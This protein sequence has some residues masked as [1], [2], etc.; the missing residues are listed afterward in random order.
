M[1]WEAWFTLSVVGFILLALARNWAQ[2]DIILAGALTVLMTAGLVSGSDRLPGPKAAV[3]GFGNAGPLT[4]GVLF[5]V[6]QGL[7]RTGAMGRLTRPFLG[8]PRGAFGA[9]CRLILPV[10]TLSAFLNNTP[11]VAMFMPVLSDWARKARISPSRLFIPLSYASIFGG[12]CTLIGT[13]TNLVIAGLVVADGDLPAIGMFDIA[14]IGLPCAVAGIVYMLL[15]GRWL[16]PDRKP[17]VSMNDDPRQYTVE[18]IVEPGGVLVGKTIEQAGLRHLPGLYLVEIERR[19][20]KLLPAVQPDRRLDGGDRLV[21]VGVV[22]SVVDLQQIRGLRPATEQVF[23]LSGAR[24]GRCLVEAVV[25][26]NCPLIGKTIR[27]G[28]FRSH[29]DAVVIAVARDGKH[30]DGK[31]GDIQLRAGDTLLLETAAGFAEKQRNSRDFYLVS[32][33]DDSAPR[34]HERAPLALALLG[35]MVAVVAVGWLD[36]LTASMLA[37]GL[38][39]LTRCCSG[40]EARQSVDWGVLVVI[41]AA[42]G[43]GK[44]M[45]TSGAASSIAQSLLALVGDRPWLVLAS[46]YA[47]TTLF[48]E[49]IT[50]NAAAALMFPLAVASARTLGVN[51]MPFVFCLMIAASA[52]FATPLGYQTNLMVYGPGGYRF[53]DYLRIGLPLNVLFFA[54]AVGLAPL[55][56]PF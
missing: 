8:M 26:R 1:S 20:G 22:E 11:I 41:G 9:Q 25:A 48:T 2:P 35:A 51:P 52:S 28:R 29:Y 31:I 50:N 38:M 16:L 19:D 17:A 15:F 13:S 24:H 56:W 21:F 53:R 49:V 12:I 27:E 10:T 34:R 43:V 30:L 44:A 45:E 39:I 54:V 6:V 46:V 18:M 14:L 32:A 33:L 47:L 36:M 55:I 3:S 23:K 40:Q 37:A 7:V 4:V 5:V 42:L